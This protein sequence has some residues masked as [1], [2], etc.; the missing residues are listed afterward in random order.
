M[1]TRQLTGEQV[2]RWAA[3]LRIGMAIAERAE[4]I[5]GAER[6]QIVD[7]EGRVLYSSRFEQE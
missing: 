2:S 3:A 7:A 6:F 5:E 4:V 1:T